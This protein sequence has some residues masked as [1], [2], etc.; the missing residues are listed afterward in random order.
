AVLLGLAAAA[1]ALLTGCGG[2][3][4]VEAPAVRTMLREFSFAVVKNEKEKIISYFL[5][6]AGQG[7]NPV[8]AKGWDTPDGRAE[9]L[10]GNRRNIRSIYKDA[11]ILKEEDV[12]RF[13]AAVRLGF[14]SSESCD[15]TFEIAGEGRRDSAKVTLRLSRRE[16]GW[17]IHDYFRDMIPKK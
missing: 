14:A 5:P 11:G 6:M 9:I 2:D 1:A 16:E 10:E 15:V 8:G 4:S 13:L 17:R 3:P 12:D 7:D